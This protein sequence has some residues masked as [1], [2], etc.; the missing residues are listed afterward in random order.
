MRKIIV[1]LFLCFEKYDFLNIEFCF[2]HSHEMLYV[3]RQSLFS[4]FSLFIDLILLQILVKHI[5]I[6]ADMKRRKT[7]NSQRPWT[8]TINFEIKAFFGIL[9]YT[10]YA[11]MLRVCQGRT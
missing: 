11:R 2:F 8:L 1:N 7:T 3:K 10:R 9:L 5:N 6:H 4:L